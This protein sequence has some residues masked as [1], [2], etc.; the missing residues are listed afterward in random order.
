MDNS[1]DK[2]IILDELK[3]ILAEFPAYS[4]LLQWENRIHNSAD[5][6]IQDIFHDFHSQ[7][8]WSNNANY[9]LESFAHSY[10]EQ[11][12]R[13]A[14]LVERAKASLLFLNDVFYDTLE[15]SVADGIIENAADLKSNIERE[16]EDIIK[17]QINE[18]LLV[19][20]Y[21]ASIC[22]PGCLLG[23][24]DDSVEFNKCAHAVLND[25]LNTEDIRNQVKKKYEDTRKVDAKKYYDQLVKERK[26]RIKTTL[27]PC[28]VVVTPACDFAQNKAKYDRIISG[29]IIDA[30]YRDFIDNKSE[31]IYISPIF[32]NDS[33]K[34][35]LILNFRYF[36]T[37]KLN[38]SKNITS[39]LRIRNSILSEIQSKLA[40]HINR[41]G[42]MNL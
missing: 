16:Q 15:A 31:A 8:N 30:C 29:V 12:Y 41:Q 17:S 28:G 24:T 38:Q 4:Y 11:Q 34:R 23:S 20:K 27:L 32:N 19:S 37:E 1:K 39:N 22:Q 26:D 33:Q 2:Q 42:I 5:A 36:Y 3:R 9:I 10:L 13:N 25:S 40:R 18:K 6:S 14:S 21:I 7:E 35:I